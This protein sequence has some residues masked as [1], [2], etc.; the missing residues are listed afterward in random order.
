[1]TIF[2]Y[3]FT[4]NYDPNFGLYTIHG[5]GYYCRTIQSRSEALNT[6]QA[7][8]DHHSIPVQHAEAAKHIDDISRCGYLLSLKKVA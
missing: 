5:R 2:L 7:L 3:H 8:S 1:M 6:I 4:I